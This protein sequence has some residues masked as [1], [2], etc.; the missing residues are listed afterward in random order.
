MKILLIAINARY[1]HTNPAVYGLRGY[2]QTHG[3]AAQIQIM[4][5]TT[6]DRYQDVLDKVLEQEP[7]AAAFSTYIWNT[8]RAERLIRERG[9]DVLTYHQDDAAVAETA[10]RLGASFIAYNAP[11]PDGTKH[12][13]A[14]VRCRWDIFYTD[15]LRRY[16][17][18]ELNA[19][20]NHWIGIDR[21]AVDLFSLAVE[22]T[23]QERNRLD[24]LRQ[25]LLNRRLVF[26]GPLYDTEGVL[27]CGAGETVGDDTLLESMGWLVR[28]VTS[29]E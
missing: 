17:K 24:A 13:L 27:R 15:M 23:E 10:D 20:K 16:L 14:A 26:L 19:V 5:F 2:A 21:G 6:G 28:G 12:G 4:E 1:I 29:L 25:E 8:E 9:A 18:G 11:I 7:D 22:V 3:A